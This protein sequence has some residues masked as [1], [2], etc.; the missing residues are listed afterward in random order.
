MLRIRL[1]ALLALSAAALG[2][3]VASAHSTKSNTSRAFARFA[4]AHSAKS[5]SSPTFA[6]YQVNESKKDI[7][8][9]SV[10]FVV[11]TITCKKDF[12]G[13]GPSVLIDSTVVHN[14]YSDSGG[15]I[16]VVC[17]NRQ[18][19]YVAL[20]VVDGTNYDDTNVPISAGN[21]ITVTV[22]YGAKTKVT[23]ENDTTHQ[24]DTHTGKKSVGET[25]YFGDS[26]IQINH[27]GVGLDP[28]TPTSF[29]A[30]KVNGR[31]IGKESPQRYQWVDKHGHVLVTAGALSGQDA[32]TTTF[33]QSS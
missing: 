6:G 7:K 13:V 32:F 16:A 10:T 26:G 5:S 23:L 20:P 3:G 33:K 9:A 25:A 22:K 17:E 1:C 28:F 24:I 21:K 30:A 12:S 15:G 11:P 4:P 29:S 8:G 14:K 2:A 27:K 18:P 19:E 31:P